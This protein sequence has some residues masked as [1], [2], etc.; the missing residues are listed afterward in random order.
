MLAVAGG[1]GAESARISRT[2]E[3]LVGVELDQLHPGPADPSED[4]HAG[5][6]TES[7]LAVHQEMVG[8]VLRIGTV[9][10]DQV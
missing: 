5:T 9:L 1:N 6:G 8:C 2:R 3:V 7:I 4:Q 10:V